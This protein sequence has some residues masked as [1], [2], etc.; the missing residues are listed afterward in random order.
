[1]HLPLRLTYPPQTRRH[2]STVAKQHAPARSV[3]ARLFRSPPRH[4]TGPA[5]ARCVRATPRTTAPW[6]PTVRHASSPPQARTPGGPDPL[7]RSGRCPPS[8]PAHGTHRREHARSRAPAHGAPGPGAPPPPRRSRPDPRP[9]TTVPSATAGAAH[10]TTTRP[11]HPVGRS[12]TPPHPLWPGPPPGPSPA[13]AAAGER[14]D[15]R[16]PPTHTPAP[17]RSHTTPAP[18]RSTRAP[19]TPRCR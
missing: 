11:D 3:R 8:P 19:H 6:C 16:A 12:T 17:T 14:P 1:P 9:T 7:R 5:P 10:P 15:A 2:R 4:A 13:G 18:G